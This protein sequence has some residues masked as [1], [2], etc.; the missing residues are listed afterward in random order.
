MSKLL[1]LWELEHLDLK[2]VQKN[3]KRF[4]TDG[5]ESFHYPSVTTVVGLL[6]REHI[7][8]WRERVGEEEANRI[9][10][11][12]AKRGTSFHQVVEDY[13]RQEK[14]VVFQDL[15]EENR[16]RGVQPVLDEIVPI[17]LEA[18]MLSNKLQMAGR[19]DCIGIFEDA[20]SIIDF[21]TSSSFKED[22]MA[23]PWFL[24]MTAYAIMVEE[25][26]GTPIEEITAIVSLE[27]GN[28]QLFSAD[29]CEYVDE[30]Y[31]L[32]EQYSNLHGV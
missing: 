8:L 6:N 24:Q 2:T 31:K 3:G 12:A 28:F 19:V 15:I 7:K 21:K 32:R 17:C 4:Y 20:L 25:L 23:K 5:E 18:P 13:L 22:Y 10:T 14:E 26:T 29:P 16:F 1:E 27:N 11:G 9:S 30:L